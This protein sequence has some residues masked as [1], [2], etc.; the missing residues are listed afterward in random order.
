MI[1]VP[2]LLSS[3]ADIM[4]QVERLEVHYMAN[5][6]GHLYFALLSDWTDGRHEH[7]PGD[8]ELLAALVDG[9]ARLNGKHGV[10]LVGGSDSVCCIAGVSGTRGKASGS[11]GKGSEGSSTS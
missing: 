1:V 9:I 6:E 4:E 11:A 2:T 7:M 5:S 10:P 3:H 8:D